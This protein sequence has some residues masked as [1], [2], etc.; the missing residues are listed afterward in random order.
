MAESAFG[1]DHGDE[2]SK[3]RVFRPKVSFPGT[4]V[5]H[6]TATVRTTH[7]GGSLFLKPKATEKAIVDRPRHMAPEVTTRKFG[8]GLTKTGKAVA[9][10][11]G[12]SSLAA[13]VGVADK[14]LKKKG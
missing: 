2:I 5:G 7:K 10:G 14:K 6:E 4:V 3:A 11:G 8:G 9:V 12:G 13:G 1:V